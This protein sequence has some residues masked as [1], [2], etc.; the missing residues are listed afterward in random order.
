VGA[1]VNVISVRSQPVSYYLRPTTLLRTLWAHRDLI[2]QLTWRNILVR[3]RGSILGVLWSFLLPLLMLAVYTFVFGVVFKSRWPNP[4]AASTGG[5]ALTLY[6]GLVV[7]ALFSET[8]NAAPQLIVGNPNYVKRVVFPLEI[9][10]LCSLGA[11]L[12]QAFIGVIALLICEVIFTGGLSATLYWFPIV[13][14]PLLT[15]TLGLAW[16]LASL[17]VYIRDAGQVIGIVLQVLMFLSPIFYSIE[18]VPPGFQTAMRANPLTV[19]VESARS[20]LLWGKSPDWA[21]LAVTGAAS[22]VVMQL[23]YVWFMK[24]RRGFADVL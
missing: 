24:T 1:A 3:Y 14:L 15:F 16:F 7:Y 23:G 10:P 21:W 2:R 13:L 4:K 8:L 6:C 22:L 17:G 5:F 19:I 11:A 18:Q 20:T 12:F 9:L